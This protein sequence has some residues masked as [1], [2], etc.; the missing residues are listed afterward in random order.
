MTEPEMETVEPE[1]EEAEAGAAPGGLSVSKDEL[2][3]F[4]RSGVQ[5]TVQDLQREAMEAQQRMYQ[6]YAPPIWDPEVAAVSAVRVIR[7]MEDEALELYPDATAEQRAAIRAELEPFMT[8]DQARAAISSG[9]HKKLTHAVMAEAIAKGDYVPSR[10]RSKSAPTVA[11][12]PSSGTPS[13]ADRLPTNLAA[14][15]KELE[16]ALGV[17]FTRDEIAQYIGGQHF[18]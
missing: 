8:A 2:R 3:D 17:T 10:Y 14:E 15:V 7:N 5:Q 11:P 13:P 12:L 18:A 4:V 1:V 6:Q 9:L 16:K